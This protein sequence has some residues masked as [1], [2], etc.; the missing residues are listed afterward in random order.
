M[1]VCRGRLPLSN[2]ICII[3]YRT[4]VFDRWRHI[5]CIFY[6]RY[7]EYGAIYRK[8]WYAI[9]VDNTLESGGTGFL[10]P[11]PGRL[12][13]DRNPSRSPSRQNIRSGFWYQYHPQRIEILL[14]LTLVKY[15]LGIP[16]S[17]PR[18]LTVIPVPSRQRTD[19]S[20]IGFGT[21]SPDSIIHTPLDRRVFPS[22]HPLPE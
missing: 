14:T 22:K 11:D 19:L 1:Q 7:Y 15:F 9:E 17:R 5:R 4:K 2:G 3:K 16:K 10:H 18:F 21:V 12:L 20:G 8:L 13:L 6:S